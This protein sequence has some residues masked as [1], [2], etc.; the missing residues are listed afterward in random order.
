MHRP[1]LARRFILLTLLSILLAACSTGPTVRSERD[2]SAV[3]SGYATFGFFEP[4]G[5]DRAGYESLV[6]QALKAATRREMEARG[7][8]YAD[9]GA[10][11]LV[12]FNAQLA[13]RT[14]VQP[15]AMPVPPPEYY[16]YRSYVTWPDYGLVVDQYQE[17]TLNIDVVDAQ[18][19]RLIW[20]GVA[21]GRVT[22]KVQRHRAEAIDKAVA[23]IFKTYPVPARP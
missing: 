22:E 10:D 14:N 7:Y 18:R 2:A 23:E 4:A 15:R 5:T 1:P 21:I 13:D 3:F 6:T 19:K 20:E 12:N 8:R 17:G 11:L 16:G 9:S